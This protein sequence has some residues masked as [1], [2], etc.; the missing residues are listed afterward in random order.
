MLYILSQSITV[1]KIK[2]HGNLYSVTFYALSVINYLS[3]CRETTV[4]LQ[5]YIPTICFKVEITMDAVGDIMEDAADFSIVF[6]R[7]LVILNLS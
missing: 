4:E 7:S 1:N 5:P 2:G 3:V 6:S